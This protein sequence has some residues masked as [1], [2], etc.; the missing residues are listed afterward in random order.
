MGTVP[1]FSASTI[2]PTSGPEE[3]YRL[4]DTAASLSSSRW[5][6]PLICLQKNTG[7]ASL[8]SYS[9]GALYMHLVSEELMHGSLALHGRLWARL[10]PMPGEHD[11]PHQCRE[12]QHMGFALNGNSHLILKSSGSW[13]LNINEKGRCWKKKSGGLAELTGL[14]KP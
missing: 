1:V 13:G 2:E 7:K 4:V 12:S 14:Q 8:R 11:L 5:R 3:G 9:S 10:L 6:R